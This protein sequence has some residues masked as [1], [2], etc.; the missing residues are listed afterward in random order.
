M[1]KKRQAEK[2]DVFILP[3]NHELVKTTADTH[4]AIG[5][6]VEVTAELV[7]G[8]LCSVIR[9]FGKRP[10]GGQIAADMKARKA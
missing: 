10:G 7:E 4:R 5:K 6:R 2:H 3:L 9:V 1:T 8:C